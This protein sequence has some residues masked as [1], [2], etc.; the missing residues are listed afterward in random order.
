MV[1]Q[2]KNFIMQ[3]IYTQTCSYNLHGGTLFQYVYQLIVNNI[4]IIIT[5]SS[6]LNRHRSSNK[7]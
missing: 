3:I 1:I 4:K 5:H 2:K 6:M 7:I